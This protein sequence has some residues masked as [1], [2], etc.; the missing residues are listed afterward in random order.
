MPNVSEDSE[1]D[2]LG[3]PTKRTEIK[4]FQ[5]LDEDNKIGLKK[6][7]SKKLR[8]KYKNA[9]VELASDDYEMLFQ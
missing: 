4:N 1:E 2:D 9:D 5:K 7:S 8:R 3:I 6:N